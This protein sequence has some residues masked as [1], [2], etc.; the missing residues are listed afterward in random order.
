RGDTE[1]DWREARALFATLSDGEMADAHLPL[2]GLLFR[3]FHE[4]GV[5]IERLQPLADR[6]TCNEERL[7]GTLKSMPEASLREL[8]EP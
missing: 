1:E 3:L 7:V 4:Q 6:C 2:E 5:M 8:V